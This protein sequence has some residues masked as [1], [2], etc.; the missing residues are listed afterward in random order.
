MDWNIHLS[1]VP[2][3]TKRG[4]FTYGQ[5]VCDGRCSKGERRIP[6]DGKKSVKNAMCEGHSEEIKES[7]SPEKNIC[8]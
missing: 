4:L 5:L 2:T 6:F 8:S 7:L 1:K 3:F